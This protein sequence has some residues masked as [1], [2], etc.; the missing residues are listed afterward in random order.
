MGG[1]QPPMSGVLMA[2]SYLRATSCEGAAGKVRILIVGLVSALADA[3][4]PAGSGMER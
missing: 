4:Y 1:L 3:P 2:V